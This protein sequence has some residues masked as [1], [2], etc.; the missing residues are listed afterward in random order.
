MKHCEN[1]NFW[2]RRRAWAEIDLDQAQQNFE[3]LRN[4]LTEGTKICCTVKANAY[5]HGAVPMARLYE[6]LGA[7]Y[8]AVSNIEEALQ[9]REGGN[10]CPLMVLGYTPIRAAKILAEH[11]IT[12][13][14][15]S[16]EYGIQ[17]ADAAKEAG[18]Q[19]KI[20]IKLDTGMGRIGFLFRKDGADELN[21]V[22]EICQRAELIPE[23]IFT[24]FAVADDESEEG[25]VY[26]R[27]QLNQFETAIDR[28][29]QAGISFD[30]RHCA[31]SAASVSLCTKNCN[32]V[33]FGLVL[34]GLSPFSI[35]KIE[36]IAPVMTL[37][38]TISHCKELEIGESVS[39][40]RRFVAK[41]KM[42]V[43]TVP[44]GYG[45]CFWRSNGLTGGM[46]CVGEQH[47]PILGTVC[48]DQTMIDVTDVSC[49]VGDEV[50]VFGSD[51]QCSAD[52]I[53]KRNGTISYEV[54]S[55]LNHRV[56][57]CFL[58]NGTIVEWCDS[59]YHSDLDM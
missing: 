9:I 34:Y 56:P 40:G 27:E 59:I 43:A 32:M 14:V 25:R 51:E 5:G 57:R 22:I 49:K 52:A 30:I 12:Q 33:R 11:H 21:K 31:N 38:T 18:V 8:L 41:K 16:Y 13:A 54:V 44:I 17:L 47:A 19:L 4:R 50:I 15:F 28:L 2:I 37:K 26:T 58:K 20:H 23:G 7:D 55:A 46:M 1:L 48:M 10:Q 36:E 42:K 6:S 45:D 53:A 24:H 39:Y 29:S 3:A 35:Q